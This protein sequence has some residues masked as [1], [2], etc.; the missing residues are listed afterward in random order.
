MVL[1][2]TVSDKQTNRWGMSILITDM[3][4]Y[5][6]SDTSD[7]SDTQCTVSTFPRHLQISISK[8]VKLVGP[9]YRY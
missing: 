4:Q 5:S 2:D 9:I 7:T 3:I 1:S 6:I 8:F